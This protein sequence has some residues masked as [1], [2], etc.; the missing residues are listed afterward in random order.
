ML[1]NSPSKEMILSLIKKLQNESSICLSPN[2]EKSLWER[3]KNDYAH[4][5]VRD[6]QIVGCCVI[7]HDALK[8]NQA[9]K[10]VELGTLWIQ[11]Q[12]RQTSVSLE[13]TSNI[14]RIAKGK[15]LLGFCQQLKIAQQYLVTN[16]KFPFNAVANWKNCPKEVIESCQIE[17]WDS[18]DIL[19]QSRYSRVLYRENNHKLTSW[20]LIYE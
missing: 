18:S 10:Y 13:I 1:K 3:F 15:K 2:R 4:F 8:K 11:Q 5:A 12:Y 19:A 7:W 17:S 14:K 16:T 6:G 20:Y 9:S